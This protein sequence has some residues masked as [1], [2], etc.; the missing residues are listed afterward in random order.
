MSRTMALHAYVRGVLVKFNLEL[1]CTSKF[2]KKAEI[3][4]AASANAIETF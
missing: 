2:F 4:R 1:I 3:A